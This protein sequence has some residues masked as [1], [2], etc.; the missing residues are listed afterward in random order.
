VQ[1]GWVVEDLDSVVGYW[2]KL[3]LKNIR[4]TGPMEF[5]NTTVRGKKTPLTL[6]MAFTEIGDVQIEWIEPVEGRSVYDEFLESHGDGIHHLAFAVKSPE[7]LEEQIAYFN[8]RG[9][10]V[11]QRGS[12]EGTKGKGLF[13]YLDTAERGGGFTVELVYNPDAPAAGAVRDHGHEY[14]FN[15]ITQYAFAVSD[16][17]KVDEFYRGLGFGGMQIDHNISVNRN[18]RGQPG[19]FEMYLGWWRF[20][21][22]PFEWIGPI[23]GPS[24]YHEFLEERG[25]GFHHLAFNVKEMDEAIRLL[26][27]RG[28]KVNQS[29][30][31][32]SPTSKGR[33]AYFDTETR[34]GASIELLWNQPMDR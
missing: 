1:V 22:V 29:G 30:G 17:R 13:A 8:S 14:P 21:S 4:R 5:P 32:D 12:W 25:E 27:A 9:V 24:V 33:F 23:A 7:Q 20:G 2:E 11:I 10:G 18:Y 15:R 26:E 31:W 6:K 16:I 34:G 28:A 3:G 19:K